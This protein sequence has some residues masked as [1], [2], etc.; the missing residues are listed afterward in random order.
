MTNGAIGRMAGKVNTMKIRNIL[1][2]TTATI[3]AAT[4]FENRAGWKMDGDKIAVDADG[5]PIWLSATGQESSVKGET[6]ANLNAEARTHRTAK[7]AAEAA[8][9]KY[10][11]ASGK[12]IDPETATRAIETISKIDAKTLIDAGKVD[13]VREQMRNEFTGQITELNNG[14]A[15][16]DNKINAMMIDGVFKGSEFIAERVA[17]PR[18][19][20][21]SN[22]RGNF[23]VEDGKIAAY[24]KAGNRI[25]SKK[26]VGDYADPNEALEILVD[27]HPQKDHILKAPDAGGSGNNGGGGNR[28]G[29]RTI[30]RADF[31][32]FDPLK[33][34]QVAVQASKGEM[35]IV[36]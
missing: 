12:L 35:S 10:R 14:L 19:F 9:A 6:I 20:F 15:E 2:A 7:E 1:L 26:S 4:A 29:G 8:L 25:M 23:K 18:D 3:V 5:N 27:Q 16:R 34:S 11:D 36:D 17:M 13:E 31:D 32:A 30:K 28:G 24:D 22:M 33:Q 21:E